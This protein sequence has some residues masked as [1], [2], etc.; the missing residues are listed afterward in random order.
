MFEKIFDRRHFVVIILIILFAI[1]LYRLAQI[2][3][4]D[5]EMYREKAD[6]SFLQRI[7]LSAKR[8][9]IYDA[10]G[11]L[12]AENIPSYTVKFLDAPQN[13]AEIDRVAIELLSLLEERDEV[14]LEFP[15]QIIDNKF[16]FRDDISTRAWLA[17]NGF[18][19]NSSADYVYEKIREREFID[20]SLDVY[21]A[22]KMLLYQGISLPISVKSM[23][24]LNELNKERFLERYGFDVK[25]TADQAFEALKENFIKASDQ[26]KYTDEEMLKIITVRDAFRKQGYLSYIP[27]EIANNIS[28][29]TAIL[30]QERSMD[31]PGVSIEIDPIRNY[32]FGDSAAHV[33][34]YMGKIS[35]AREIEKYNSETGYNPNDM[36]GKTGLENTFEDVLHGEDGYKY[37]YA[38]AKGN[39][40]GDFI[41]GIPGKETKESNSGKDI[42]LT[43]DI[44]LQQ[45][46][47]HYLEY[48]LGQIQKG[49][50]YVSQWG[51]MNYKPYENAKSGAAMVVKVDTGEVL[52]LVN[53]PSYDLNLFATGITSED[54]NSLK[55]E[56]PRNPLDP[57]PLY[58]IAT[59][60]AVQPGSTFK[61]ITVLAAI[62]QGLDPE[63]KLFAAGVVE[64]GKQLYRCW[65]YRAPYHG[66]HGS[67][68]AMQALEVSCNY[69]MFDIVRGYD[70][71]RSRD[72]SFEMNTEILLDYASKFGLGEGSGLEIYENVAGLPSQD[73]KKRT[74]MNALRWFLSG[75]LDDYFDPARIA[76]EDEKALIIDE[77]TRWVDEYLD[78][79]LTRNETIRRLMALNP[80]T[81]YD[82]TSLLADYIYYSYFRQIPW[83]EGDDLNL[84][85]G[86]GDHRYTVAQMVRYVA[87]IANGGYLHE[88]TLVKEVDGESTLSPTD[89]QIEMVDVNN[90]EYIRE[91][92][93]LVAHGSSG[94]AKVVFRNFDLEVGAK[95]G[96]AQAAGRIPPADELGYIRQVFPDVLKEAN[97]GIRE[98]S[99]RYLN[100]TIQELEDETTRILEERNTELAD[101]M[102]AFY[103]LEVG[104]EKEALS[105]KIKDKAQG[106]YLDQGFIMRE[107]L[108]NMSDDRITNEM[109]DSYR[110]EYDPFTWFISFAPYEDPEIAVVVL[111][112]QGGSGGYAAP[113]VRDIY[114]TYFDLFE[115]EKML[116]E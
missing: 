37:I 74:Q 16:Y 28:K 76:N 88:L 71:Y 36:I 35:S 44:E 94:S 10:N 84:S 47:E 8:G 24:F 68:N 30:I 25:M 5:G 64:L 6:D 90:L 32:P 81:D 26:E 45:A 97:A 62:E 49:E 43:I 22:Q 48:G 109:I 2:T 50:P 114:G 59:N 27:I 34:G 42:Q 110:Q 93:R 108:L 70:Y 65:Y 87:A 72:L 89:E 23:K 106:T 39:Y 54:Y 66:I 14:Y 83:R 86:Q 99:D 29:E 4:I 95:T 85:I 1:L 7:T 77:I 98:S 113:I 56:N 60:T 53:Y 13:A 57:R 20:E 51:Q 31:F 78:G 100:I 19:V 3:I 69:F 92:M 102:N 104:E 111:I 80:V 33:I 52:A 61:P 73:V 46:V 116:M 67:I 115:H 101:L 63:Q 15:I 112:P 103:E 79:T 9:D 58:N 38:D 91:G 55:P 18:P 21:G 41:E 17:S 96:T 11:V 12:L 105:E 40:I 75:V 107:V 82:E